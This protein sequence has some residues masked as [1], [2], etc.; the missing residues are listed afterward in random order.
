MPDEWLFSVSKHSGNAPF[1]SQVS[2]AT[3]C[4]SCH[5]I[6]ARSRPVCPKLPTCSCSLGC[7]LGVKRASGFFVT[8]LL[9][10]VSFSLPDCSAIKLLCENEKGTKEDVWE[11]LGAKASCTLLCLF[12]VWVNITLLSCVVCQRWENTGTRDFPLSSQTWVH[13]ETHTKNCWMLFSGR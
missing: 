4:L 10:C 3:I 11:R 13:E 8:M 1:P 6:N 7:A 9:V 12:A 2:T 5:R